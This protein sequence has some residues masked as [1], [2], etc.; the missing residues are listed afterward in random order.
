MTISLTADEIKEIVINHL[1]NKYGQKVQRI[2]TK[3]EIVRGIWGERERTAF[4]GMDLVLRK[5]DE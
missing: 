4:S 2:Y 3:F 5:S 1:E